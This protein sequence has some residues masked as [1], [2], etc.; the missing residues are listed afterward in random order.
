MSPSAVAVG[1]EVFESTPELVS[2]VSGVSV[3]LGDM[4][5]V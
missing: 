3:G 5:G 2:G 1:S 4:R